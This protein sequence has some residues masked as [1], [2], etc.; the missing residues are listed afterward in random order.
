VAFKTV[1]LTTLLLPAWAKCLEDLKI[2]Y[3]IIPQ[4]VQ[5][6]WNSTYDMLIFTYK[7]QKA[8]DNFTGDRGNDLHQFE[9]KE[10]DWGL[11]KQL[12]D[13]LEVHLFD[14]QFA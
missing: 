14:P 9:L 10:N 6:R 4:D 3:H 13:I 8:F 1:H 2:P 12:C 11:V 7:H 5:T